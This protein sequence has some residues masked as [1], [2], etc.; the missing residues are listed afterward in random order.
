MTDPDAQPGDTVALRPT[1][2][3]DLHELYRF[4]LEQR[5]NEMAVVSPRTRD[6]FAAHWDRVLGDREVVA[7]TVVADG[8]IV[9]SIS[10]Y[11]D[12]GRPSVGFWIGEEFWGRGLAT[13]ALR[14][15]LREVDRRPLH[16]RVANT[17]AG[18]LRVL[19]KC[20]F[21]VTGTAFVEATPRFPA[22]HETYLRLDA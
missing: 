9:G 3:G 16:A 12:E 1:E 20:G 2:P 13:A 11:A 17:N 19:Q 6:D 7:R 10:V 4:Q 21:E 5:G 8:R 18:S 22:C 14:L 15:L